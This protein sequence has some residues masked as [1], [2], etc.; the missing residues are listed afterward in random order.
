MQKFKTLATSRLVV[1]LGGAALALVVAWPLMGTAQDKTDSPKD[2]DPHAQHKDKQ[3]AGD[4]DL[5]GQIAELH[6]KV[7]RLEAALPKSLPGKTPG[8]SGMGTKPDEGKGGMEDDKMM[9]GMGDKKKGMAGGMGMDAMEPD[10]MMGQMMQNM[11]QMMQMMGQMKG[12]GMSGMGGMGDKQKAGMGGM[13]D[14]GMA[15]MGD[16]GMAGMGDK[17]MGMMDMDMQEMM[18]M[19]GKGGMG[20][21]TPGMGKMQMPT[22]LPGF[23]GASHIYHIGATGFFLDHPTTSS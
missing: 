23:P 13:G 1:F 8:M 5:T 10:E 4:L 17:G 14:K 3:A 19:M 15:G 9:G 2:P 18:G 6:A 12:K 21:K 16:K 7:A 11:G 22:A 20:Q